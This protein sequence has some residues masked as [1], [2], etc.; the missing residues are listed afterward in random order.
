MTAA[1]VVITNDS[2]LYGGSRFPHLSASASPLLIPGLLEEAARIT[3]QAVHWAH[4]GMVR[5]RTGLSVQLAC[6][7]AVD[8]IWRGFT[9]LSHTIDPNDARFTPLCTRI[10]SYLVHASAEAF[11]R[12]RQGMAKSHRQISD[13]ASQVKDILTVLDPD[14]PQSIYDALHAIHRRTMWLGSIV[15]Q[16]PIE[17]TEYGTHERTLQ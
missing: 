10:A 2:Y 17:R 4:A 15:V 7:Y 8:S 14:D 6:D 12:F 11:Q 9:R 1:L 5:A 16:C 3:T 13:E